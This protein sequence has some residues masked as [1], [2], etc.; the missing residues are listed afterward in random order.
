MTSWRRSRPFWGGLLI[1]LAGVELLSIPLAINALPVVIL[2]GPVGAT[3]LIALVM[4]ILGVLLWLQPGQRVFLGIVT[5]LLS[6]AS[7]VYSNLGGF[8]IGMSLGL[9]GG[10]LALAWAPAPVKQPRTA[11]AAPVA[12]S[13]RA[14]R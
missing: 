14:V 4:M 13:R 9:V 7:F 5:V 2:F 8:L 12:Q 11:D 1:V 10:T 6:M 3:Y